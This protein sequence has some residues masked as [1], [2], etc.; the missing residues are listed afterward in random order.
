MPA[1]VITI[2][3]LAI[4][5]S[6]DQTGKSHSENRGDVGECSVHLCLFR[7]RSIRADLLGGNLLSGTFDISPVGQDFTIIDAQKAAGGQC[8]VLP[9]LLAECRPKRAV[10]YLEE[11]IYPYTCRV[12]LERRSH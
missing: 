8:L 11:F 10:T 7:K 6:Y 12:H 2:Y 5:V 4:Y 1:F 9:E 3:R